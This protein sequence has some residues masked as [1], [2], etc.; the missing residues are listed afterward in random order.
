M[1]IFVLCNIGIA[2]GYFYAAIAVMPKVQAA[3]LRTKIGGVV[4]FATCGLTH[5]ELAFHAVAGEISISDFSS[6]HMIIIHLVQMV[7]VWVF[8]TGLYRELV[9]GTIAGPFSFKNEKDD[10]DD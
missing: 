3:L 9:E 1:T 4:F 2:A 8:L 6:A 10:D 7:A 5:L